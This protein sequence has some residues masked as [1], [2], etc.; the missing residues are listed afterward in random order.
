MNLNANLAWPVKVCFNKGVDLENSLP[1]GNTFEKYF[2][3]INVKSIRKS[4]DPK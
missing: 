4:P 3:K 1:S 2:D